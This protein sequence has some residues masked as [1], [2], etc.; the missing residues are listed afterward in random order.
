[1]KHWPTRSLGEIAG[2]GQYGL[3]A[4]AMPE[5]TG[6]RFIR[7]TDITQGGEL[8]HEEPAFVREEMLNE[9]EL[10]DGDVLIARSG[11]TAGKSYVHQSFGER[12]VFAGYLIRFQPDI[13]KVLPRF[14]GAFLQTP[15]YW[16]QLNSHKRAVAQPNVNAKQLASIRLPVPSL[17]EQERLVI[18]LNE[19]DGLRKLR[20]QADGRTAVLSSALF[21][22]LFG[23]HIKSPAVLVSLEGA[24][25]PKGWRWCRLTD[26]ARLATG[27]TPSRRVPAYWSGKIPWISLT[28]IRSLDGS[29]AYETS[30]SVTEEGIENSSAVKLP[31]GTVCFSRTASVGF[32]TV[33]GREMCT[34]QDFVNWVCGDQIDPIYLMSALLQA[35]E[36]LRSLASGSTHKTIYFPTVEQFCIAV[37]PLPLQKQF[38]S[39]VAEIREL[40]GEQ[41]TSR[42]RLD[43]LFQSM[44]HRAFNGEL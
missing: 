17:A 8:R 10:K 12:A 5:G 36:H 30:Q 6:I 19:A 14:I 4:A 34:S 29:I 13:T 9:Y 42:R 43:D 18:L 37:P 39:R 16:R 38:A 33:M 7:I 15:N 23:R 31:K 22:E 3:N 1:M 28:D 26:V 32:V 20:A 27:H 25:A 11:A 41:A 21:H 24:T 44:L 40:E 2:S 35:R